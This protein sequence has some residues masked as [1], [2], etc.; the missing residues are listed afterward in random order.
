MQR[1]A[2]RTGQSMK[3]ILSVLFFTSACFQCF[4]LFHLLRAL[5]S[6]RAAIFFLQE[7]PI[8]LHT[9]A[10]CSEFWILI[11]IQMKKILWSGSNCVHEMLNI[12]PYKKSCQWKVYYA[13][14]KRLLWDILSVQ[15]CTANIYSISWG[16]LQ[17]RCST[18]I[19]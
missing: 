7:K 19:R 4:W 2:N 16:I 17:I 1:G 11:G 14:C 13:N 9:C 10:T 15:K 3:W 18:D 12:V 5:L 6:L 8:F